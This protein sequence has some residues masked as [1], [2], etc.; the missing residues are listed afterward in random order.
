MPAVI[1]AILR[2]IVM[3]IVTG[4]IVTGV[5]EALD[6]TLKELVFE[7]K[8][9]KGVTEQDAKDIVHNILVDMALNSAAILTALKLKLPTKTAQYLGLTTSSPKK[10]VLSAAATTAAASLIKDG[11]K[12]VAIGML[13]KLLKI[14]KNPM[15]YFWA[16]LGW[17]QAIEPGI[18]QPK[19]ANDV[20][21]KFTGLRP[22]P[23]KDI[24]LQPGPFDAMKFNEYAKALEVAGI[25]GIQN[26]I[27]LQSQ[28][29]SREGLA[30]I[31][32]YVYGQEVTK[33]NA[34][35]ATKLIPL[36]AKYLIG[37]GTVKTTSTTTSAPTSQAT[38]TPTVKVFTGVVSQG[39]VGEGLTFQ[40]RVDDLI[41]DVNEL[42]SAAA[43]NLAPFLAALP[44]KVTYEIKVVS[45]I[46]TT[47][48]FKQTGTTQKVQT[49]TNRDGSPKYKMVTNK[50]A[51]L[52]LYVLTDRGTRT[53][54][55]TIVL[56]PV[57]SARFTVTSNDLITLAQE[58][59]KVVTTSNTDDITKIT[60]NTP[61]ETA[62]PA[63]GSLG[64]QMKALGILFVK[65]TKADNRVFLYLPAHETPTAK[66]P[67]F[68]HEIK[69]PENLSLYGI[70]PD[71]L[72]PMENLPRITDG[73]T[74]QDFFYGANFA[75]NIT[76]EEVLSVLPGAGFMLGTV[77]VVASEENPKSKLGADAKTLSEWYQAQGKSLPSVQE[78]SVT[79]QQ[80][81]LGQSNYYSGTAEQ[82]TKLLSALKAQ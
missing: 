13:P 55:S 37:V 23:E 63:Q 29:Y 8:D 21:Q 40:P 17:T 52:I 30:D 20:Y 18:Y 33:G 57:D 35:S 1:I 71:M 12:S 34:P 24:A 28:Y 50:F 39:V 31:I 65:Y 36:L 16:Y 76:A 73:T 67:K 54:L 19:Q 75:K 62:M 44:A 47:N 9:K 46:T 38:S 77:P 11:G 69:N 61:T 66:Y 14:F 43:N 3:A 59:P 51:T 80:L 22:F 7:V 78:R 48:G 49:G 4:A 26:P 79:Y 64:A 27:A 81:G 2:Q 74:D 72:T 6:G 60:S 5:Q 10:K 45:S 53:K 70:T 15:T 82:N 68:V 41:E 42:R 32:N 25:K 56:G 58:L